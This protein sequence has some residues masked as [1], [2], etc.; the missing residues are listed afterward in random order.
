[1]AFKDSGTAKGFPKG[2]DGPFDAGGSGVHSGSDHH[3]T[4]AILAGENDFPALPGCGF[5]VGASFLANVHSGTTP[6]TASR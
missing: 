1:M 6:A 5:S 3:F 4:S 2:H